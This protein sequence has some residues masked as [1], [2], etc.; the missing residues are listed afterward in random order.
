M[1]DNSHVL[2]NQERQK[3]IKKLLEQA[4]NDKLVR[5]I[6]EK[7]KPAEAGPSSDIVIPSVEE[8]VLCNTIR[9]KK[10]KG[11]GNGAI[12]E[13][14]DGRFYF[15]RDDNQKGILCKDPAHRWKGYGNGLIVRMGDALIAYR[16]DGSEPVKIYA[17]PWDHWVGFGK[18]VIVKHNN[19]FT[20]YTDDKKLDILREGPIEVWGGYGKGMLIQREDAKRLVILAK[21]FNEGDFFKI[22]M[23]TGDVSG[24]YK[25]GV[26][27]HDQVTGELIAYPDNMTEP[28]IL[29]ES[30]MYTD[31]F[32][33]YGNGAIVKREG[34]LIAYKIVDKAKRLKE[35]ER[36]QRSRL[37]EN[38]LEDSES[39]KKKQDLNTFYNP[40]RKNDR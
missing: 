2:G 4:G 19:R 39:E 28:V 7:R 22:Y 26:V 30:V 13:K 27:V 25:D 1:K 15:F 6:T 20:A 31:G 8:I 35:L 29:L 17:G 21:K 24:G 33:N 40:E 18:G 5:E 34:E 3:G 9:V 37:L 36:E 11:Y 32:V 23:G 10:W 14:E 16:D 12:V 38:F